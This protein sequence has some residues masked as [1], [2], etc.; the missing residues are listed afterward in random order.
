RSLTVEAPRGDGRDGDAAVEHV[1]LPRQRHRRHEAAIAPAPHGHAA[2]VHE[3][4]R[5]A[6]LVALAA[7]AAAVD[8]RDDEVAAP[9]QPPEICTGNVFTCGSAILDARST[10]AELFCRVASRRGRFPPPAAREPRPGP[11]PGPGPTFS[12]GPAP[13]PTRCRPAATPP[14]LPLPP[15]PPRPASP[16][17]AP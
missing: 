1:L 10:S 7:G 16:A 8:L 9:G 6:Q 14:P 12:P 13:P 5:I 17:A 2:R 3:V 11:A 4:Q 15:P